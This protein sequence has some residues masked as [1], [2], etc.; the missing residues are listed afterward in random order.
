M[1]NFPH[2]TGKRP[3]T[4]ITSEHDSGTSQPFGNISK[5]HERDEMSTGSKI[6][7]RNLAKFAYLLRL[8]GRTYCEI[9]AEI[10]KPIEQIKKLILLGERLKSIEPK[11]R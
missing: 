5:A 6:R 3:A 11:E 4:G 1:E 10:N 2:T 7:S 9:A 8:D